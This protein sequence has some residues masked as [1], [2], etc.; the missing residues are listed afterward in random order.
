MAELKKAELDNLAK[1][2]ASKENQE[3]FKKHGATVNAVI[4]F[5]PNGDKLNVLAGEQLTQMGIVKYLKT[6]KDS[7]AA[8]QKLHPSK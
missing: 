3:L 7:L 8:W 5:A 1:V 2:P 4:F 6:F